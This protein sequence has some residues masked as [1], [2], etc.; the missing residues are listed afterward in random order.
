VSVE[1]KPSGVL[2]M[3]L[4]EGPVW[5]PATGQLSVVD[6]FGRKVHYLA[7]GK[8]GW[9][10]VKTTPT[11]SDVGAALTLD[12]GEL[13]TCEQAGIFLHGP[14]G[15]E[16][17]APLPVPGDEFRAN[18]AKL[19]PD[20]RL[21]VGVMHYEATA[22]TGSLWAVNRAGQSTLLLEGLTIPNGMDWW[23]N[24]VWF[25]NG[26]SPEIRCYEMQGQSLHDTGRF[27]ST[28]GIPDGLSIDSAGNIWV[29]LWGEGRVDCLSRSGDL[30]GSVVLPAPH[31]TSVAFVG[32][33][34]REI[35]V[36]TARFGLSDEQLELYA[37]SGDVFFQPVNATGS[38]SF[39]AFV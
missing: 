25:V 28:Q 8:S 7:P 17:I 31:T 20:G 22:E 9:E 26:P 30:L 18:D 37:H 21:F 2:Q 23:G 19:G 32:A 15:P 4:G 38:E 34:R 5:N 36:T 11:S 27:I 39:R 33:H 14:S 24:E 35:A 13:L 3:E 10:R 12:S 1:A 6:I 29:A 16:L